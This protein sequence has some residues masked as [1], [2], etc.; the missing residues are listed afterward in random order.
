MPN[1]TSTEVKLGNTA[2]RGSSDSSAR[3]RSYRLIKEWINF[4][5]S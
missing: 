2:L 3:L 5:D 4:T 1:L